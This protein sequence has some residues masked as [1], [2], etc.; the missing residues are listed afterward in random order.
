[1]LAGGEVE[2]LLQAG[3]IAAE[4]RDYGAG[5]A[6]PG[7][8]AREIC[9]E[10]ESLIVKRGGRPAF[11]CNL[12]V[13][14]VAAHYTPGV[15]DDVRLGSGDVV[16]IDVGAHIDGY[17]ADTA[18]TV[19]LGGR[20][21]G[22]L[23]ASRAALEAVERIMRPGVSVYTLG[24]TIEQEIRGGGTSRSGTSPGTR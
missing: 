1:M 8:S 18:V 17:I 23:E 15:R 9:E 11:P 5:L 7:A 13:N 2:K 19:D 12:S 24:R 21:G 14:E 3:R 10:V 16:K 22:L 6:R 4:A 20:H